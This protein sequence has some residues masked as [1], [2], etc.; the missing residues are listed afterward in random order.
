MA[1]WND[2]TVAYYVNTRHFRYKSPAHTCFMLGGDALFH[3]SCRQT[4][5]TH[6]VLC[7]FTSNRTVGQAGWANRTREARAYTPRSTNGLLTQVRTKP[8]ERFPAWLQMARCPGQHSTFQFLACDR[9]AHCWTQSSAA[10]SRS[11]PLRPAMFT[12]TAGGERVPYSLVCDHR[13]DCP[14]HTDEDFCVFP[15]CRQFGYHNCGGKQCITEDK[16][17]NGLIDCV[18]EMDETRC[19]KDSDSFLIRTIVPSQHPS[20]VD[21]DGYGSIIISNL[22]SVPRDADHRRCPEGYFQCPASLHY[23]LP[24]HVLCNGVRDCPGHEDEAAC[25]GFTCPGHYRCRGSPMCLHASRLCDGRPQCPQHDDEAVCTFTRC[26]APCTCSGLAWHCTATL[27]LPLSPRVRFLDA[28]ATQTSLVSLQNATMLVFL[29][30]S[31]CEL[32][33]LSGAVVLPNLRELRLMNNKLTFIELNSLALL[34]NLREISLSG[35]PLLMS[36]N[37]QPVTDTS[38]E[39]VHSL[40]LSLISTPRLHT[41]SLSSFINVQML[42][43]SNCRISTIFRGFRHFRKLGILDLRGNDLQLFPRDIFQNIFSLH[44]V[45]TDNFKLC[46]PQTLPQGFDPTRCHGPDHALSSCENLLS[47]DVYRFVLALYACCTLLGN[48]TSFVYR[49][50]GKARAHKHGY[51]AFVLH[52]CSSDLCMGI[53]L[54]IVGVADHYYR[55][56]Y[57]WK[58]TAWKSSSACSVA[59]FLSL[60][61]S[62]VSAILICLITLDRFLVLRFPF[63]DVRFTV[64]SAHV[65]CCLVWGVGLFLALIPLLPVTSHWGFYRQTGICLPLPFT[66]VDFPG[67]AYSFTIM[68]V[69]NFV[70]FLFIAVGQAC[71]YWSVRAGALALAAHGGSGIHGGRSAAA[72]DVTMARRLV[73]VAVSDFLCWFPLGVLGLLA[74]AGRVFPA[75][76]NVAAAIVVLPLNAAINPALYTLNVLL[77]RRQ[78]ARQRRL[79][80]RLL[81][82]TDP[83]T[84]G[85]SEDPAACRDTEAGKRDPAACRDTEAGKKTARVSYTEQEAASLVTTW[86]R[87]GLV[88]PHRLQQY[89]QTLNN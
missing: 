81:D 69:F 2:G 41:L 45:F 47:S 46:C 74:S 66:S 14:D 88:T 4:F 79:L 49:L 19:A 16:F 52:L 80:Q 82:H 27:H 64:F 65:A 55:N 60:L 29:D 10:C 32:S 11:P 78:R 1:V 61:S 87:S 25:E 8:S 24:V 12:C 18:S 70:L 71:I 63:S 3:F 53:Y 20:I 83:R 72:K 21:F 68:I 17:C 36:P 84:Q 76:V 33:N 43:F 28:H 57:I 30:L 5:S 62:E 7:Q 86:L 73:A 23:C 44:T 15:A 13:S 38:L 34:S 75:Q 59:G 22:T 51:N 42:N 50:A 89:L 35:N 56:V 77:E 58:D 54:A 6:H 9:A 39:S 48:L 26:P 37:S 67:H 85:W 40:D 31:D